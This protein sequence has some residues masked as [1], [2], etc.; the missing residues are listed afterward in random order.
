MAGRFLRDNAFLVAAVSLP[1]VVVVVFLLL[2]AIPKWTVPS[3][4][5]DLLLYTT[6]Y[7]RQ[8]A[9]LAVEL[10]VRDE[11]LQATVRPVLADSYPPRVR[12][13]R[14]DH[15]AQSTTEIPLDLPTDTGG[16][17]PPRTHVVEALRG[18]R[19]VTATKAP[20]GYEF[21]T[22]T[23]RGP[24]LI[25]DVFGMRR[26]DQRAVIVKGAAGS[27]GSRSRRRISTPH[28]YSSGGWRIER[29]AEFGRAGEGAPADRGHCQRT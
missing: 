28:R 8:G 17:E 29:S 1:L 19:I 20:D 27:S 11:T 23:H 15:R 26:Y 13:W 4:Q 5:H 14:F 21:R 3:P 22:P 6:D 24:G 2:T 16:G 7:D 9:R 25:G 10:L 12:L 18:R